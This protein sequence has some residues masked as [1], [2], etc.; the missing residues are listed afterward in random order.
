[1]RDRK[2][3]ILLLAIAAAIAAFFIFDLQS[4]LTLANLKAPRSMHGIRLR[5]RAA[6]F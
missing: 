1:M 6:S 4:Y 3:L 2:K 5:R